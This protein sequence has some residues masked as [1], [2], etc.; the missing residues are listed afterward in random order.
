M[1]E[2]IRFPQGGD[3]RAALPAEIK[4]V[5]SE[6]ATRIGNLV[7]NIRGLEQQIGMMEAGMS[8][9]VAAGLDHRQA[10]AQIKQMERALEKAYLLLADELGMEVPGGGDASKA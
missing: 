4:I 6:T 2:I 7:A 3:V 1:A 8:I 10:E 5:V 9:N